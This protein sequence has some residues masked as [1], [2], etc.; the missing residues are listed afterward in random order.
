MIDKGICDKGYIWNPRNFKCE[1]DRSCDIGQY[2]DYKNCKC[3]KKLVDELVEE[4]GK[5]IAENEMV[6]N[7]T[8][9]DYKKVC[10][11]C[12]IYIVLFA[13]AFLIIFSISSAFIYFHWYLI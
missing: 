8:L 6:Y 9:N 5:N 1:C 11:S 12:T 7:G 2:L 3:R 13:L 10:N 4:C